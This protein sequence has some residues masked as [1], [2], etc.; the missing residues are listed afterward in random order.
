[1]EKVKNGDWGQA[2]QIMEQYNPFPALTGY[3]CYQFCRSKCSRGEWDEPVAIRDVEKA[4]G[5]WRQEN[6]RQ[7]AL[8]V[9]KGEKPPRVIIVG[10]GPAGLCAAYYLNRM[11]AEVTVLEKEPVAGGLWLR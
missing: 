5:L 6:Y 4:L 9:K 3:A 11:G 7:R 1:M 8:A 10:S 2:W